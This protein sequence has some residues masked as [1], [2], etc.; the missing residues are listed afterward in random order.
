MYWPGAERTPSGSGLPV[1][2]YFYGGGFTIAGIDWVS[3]D[4]RLRSRARDA[5]IVIVA[6]DYAH[7]P[8]RRFPTQP[9][10]C[11]S[12]FEWTRAHA[13][14]LGASRNRIAVGGA[15]SGATSPP[16]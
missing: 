13:E 8:E 4:A 3:W 5:G 2:V 16:P 11:W 9:E 10:Q 6:A 1:L 12:A 15:S 14:Q 7:A